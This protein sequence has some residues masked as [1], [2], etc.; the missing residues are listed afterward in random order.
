MCRR[1]Q[2]ALC[3]IKQSELYRIIERAV[4]KLPYK[5][6]P[7]QSVDSSQPVTAAQPQFVH[8]MATVVRDLGETMPHQSVT[9]PNSDQATRKR[10]LV[11]ITN[12]LYSNKK[13]M[14][15]DIRSKLPPVTYGYFLTVWAR[16]FWHVKLKKW[17]PFAKCDTCVNVRY[18]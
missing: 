1:A 2:R 17:N 11:L 18:K 13:E 8:E 16:Y 7:Q 10:D 5:Y 14:Y 3:G 6:V 9:N 12:A 4:D 15:L